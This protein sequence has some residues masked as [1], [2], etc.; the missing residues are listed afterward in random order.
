MLACLDLNTIWNGFNVKAKIKLPPDFVSGYIDYY[1]VYLA[2]FWVAYQL[3]ICSN[4]GSE[5]Y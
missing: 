3:L 1:K 4:K 5:F 2:T